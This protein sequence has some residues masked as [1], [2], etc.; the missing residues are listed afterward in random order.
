MEDLWDQRVEHGCN[1]KSFNMGISTG[2]CEKKGGDV[3]RVFLD[4]TGD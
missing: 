4:G 1:P 3:A 2:V